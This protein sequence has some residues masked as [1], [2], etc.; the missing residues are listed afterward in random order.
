M[1]ELLHELYEV[2]RL[3]ILAGDP[4]GAHLR[5]EYLLRRAAVLDRLAE[6]PERVDWV[7]DYVIHA[8]LAARDLLEHDATHSSTHGAIPAD[9]ACWGNDP[10]GYARQE[11]RAWIIDT[12]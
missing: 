7:I 3:Q 5:R 2:E 9:A 8:A 10:R 6:T 4:E 12:L 11:H 1:T